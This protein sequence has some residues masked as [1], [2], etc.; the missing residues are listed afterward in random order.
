MLFSVSLYSLWSLIE[1]M[2]LFCPMEQWPEDMC[3]SPR[4]ILALSSPHVVPL[5]GRPCVIAEIAKKIA[6]ANGCLLYSFLFEREDHV[7]AVPRSWTFI[8]SALPSQ[9][10]SAA[11]IR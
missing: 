2:E 5:F 8:V 4:C 6:L 11:W 9:Y 1:I 3:S 7:I 10:S